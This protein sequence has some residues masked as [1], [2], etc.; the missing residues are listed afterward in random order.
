MG[1]YAWLMVPTTI[2]CRRTW[3]VGTLMHGFSYTEGWT[4]LADNMV[5][6]SSVLSEQW[7]QEESIHTEW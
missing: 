1:G 6:A 7:L 3:H 5:L 2:E 4:Q